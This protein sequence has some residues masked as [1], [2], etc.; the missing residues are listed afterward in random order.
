MKIKVIFTGGTISSQI[1]ESGIQT[2]KTDCVQKMLIN[3]YVNKTNDKKTEFEVTQPLN[4]LSENMTVDNWNTI[5][6]EFKNTD[7]NKYDGIIVA[8]GTDTLG[9]TTTMLSI[10]LAGINIPVV[11]VS[12][13]YV[14]TDDKANG[15]DNFYNAVKFIEST[16][17]IGVFAI[18]RDNDNRSVVYI[19]SRLNQCAYLTNSYS[20]T[21]DIDFGLMQDGK[22]VLCNNRINNVSLTD[23]I[24]EML[25]YK[26]DSLKPCVMII[27]PYTGIDYN[28]FIPTD[29]IKVIL[30][31][32]YHGGT[33]STLRACDGSCSSLIDFADRCRELDKSFYI[34]PLES[35]VTDNYATTVE[36]KKHGVS[37]LY[38][39]SIEC[40]YSKLIIAYS[41]DNLELRNYIL[42][43]NIFHETVK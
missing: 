28:C 9:F 11:M 16:D 1:G 5:L 23:N 15:N 17:Y 24:S 14:L 3:N 31:S 4:I 30:H 6:N 20:S 13:N 35:A 8:H 2:D 12:S 18:Y 42:K 25:L 19:G 29:K 38:D 40:A 37:A 34:A 21:T 33:A 36:M 26:I 10:M 27:N 7:F 41:T 39:I 22:F 43:T 32:L